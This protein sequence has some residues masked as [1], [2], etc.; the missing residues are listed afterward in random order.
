VECKSLRDE[1]A[2]VPPAAEEELHALVTA[3]REIRARQCRTQETVATLGG[4]GRKYVSQLEGGRLMPSFAAL[5]AI[6]RG[7]GVPL[8]ELVRVYEE[9]LAA[10]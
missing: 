9:R 2:G 10:G 1:S 8:S 4:V 3:V 6:A 5:V 7:L